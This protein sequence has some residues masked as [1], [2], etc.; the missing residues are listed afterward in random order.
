MRF[1]AVIVVGLLAAACGTTAGTQPA[2]LL[3]APSATTAPT[4]ASAVPSP[5]A[6]PGVAAPVSAGAVPDAGIVYV[7]GADDG[8][9]RYDGA[10]GALTRVSG[11]ST[12]ARESADGPY[13]LGRHGGTTLLRWDGTTTPA[14]GGGNWSVVSTRGQCAWIGAAT[15]GA[16]YTDAP[17]GGNGATEPRMLLPADWG[18]GTFAWDQSGSELA[19]IRND[20]R[21]EPVRQH[22][23]L[24]VMDVRDGSP[25]KVFDPPTDTSFIFGVKWSPDR[26]VS[27]W[28]S[29]TTSASFGA[30]GV[31]TSLHVVN[32]DTA[33]DTDL[34][35]TLQDRAWAQWS[36]D[37]RL[38]FVRGGGRE[39]WF[40]KELVVLD[41]GGRQRVVAGDL[42][43]HPTATSWAALAPAWQP[44]YGQP[45]LVWVES[46]AI[47]DASPDYFRGIGPSAERIAVAD[48]GRRITCPGLVTEGVRLSA[49]ATSAL[50]L[51]RIPGVEHHALQ[52]WYAAIG[53]ASHALVTGLGD[54][55]FGFYG[56]QPSLFDMTAWS[57]A[58]R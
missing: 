51:C 39:T 30:D 24:W 27:F 56:M 42:S 19:I 41:A 17:E 15:D 1:I 48:D 26:R 47:T 2:V 25:R 8:I 46:P 37:G 50:L 43:V 11:A 23:T 52:L 14:C 33:A 58:D 20:A 28:E 44:A 40:S 49:G 55:G 35:T 12:L 7:W 57:L 32:V 38:A 54:L 22:Q 5:T 29:A 21:P 31:L 6:S 18:A 36:S 4:D 53:G 9:Y 34:G 45:Q 13:V 16:V 3:A 10:T